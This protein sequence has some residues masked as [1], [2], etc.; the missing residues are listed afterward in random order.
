VNLPSTPPPQKKK[1]EN[2]RT[3]VNN[4]NELQ[5]AVNNCSNILFGKSCTIDICPVRLYM[6]SSSS[7]GIN[8]SNKNI[9]FNCQKLC[10]KMRCIIDGQ[11]ISRMFYGST[12][13]FTVQN[14]IVMK[15]VQSRQITIPLLIL[16]T[17]RL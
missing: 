7:N 5:E 2:Q 8:L 6:E 16:S 13:N 14:F 4:Q 9:V 11:G 10:P 15:V 1:P 3:C 17:V 12:C